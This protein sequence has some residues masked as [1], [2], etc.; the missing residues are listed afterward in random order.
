MPGKP[1][2]AVFDCN[3]F[4]QIFFSNKGVGARCRELVINKNFERN[5][6]GK[7]AVKGKNLSKRLP[8]K[9]VV[10]YFPKLKIPAV[11]PVDEVIVL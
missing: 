4:W 3:I 5:R 7:P 1:I 9:R 10:F 6:G 8:V 11:F 2:R